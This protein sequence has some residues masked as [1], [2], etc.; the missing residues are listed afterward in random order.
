MQWLSRDNALRLFDIAVEQHRHEG[1]DKLYY[2][3]SLSRD[4]AEWQRR[5][6]YH[7]FVLLVAHPDIPLSAAEL[8]KLYR[9]KDVIERDFRL[10]KDVVELRPIYHHTDTKVRA[11]VTLCVLALLLQ[12][13]LEGRLAA[14]GRPMT[15]AAC[16]ETLATCRL[17]RYEPNELLE[18][19][20]SVTQP[21][22]EQMAILQ[23]LGLTSLIRHQELATRITPR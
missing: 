22:P 21:S 4:Q 11:H 17:N 8:A 6:R 15:A 5:R 18:F 19:D 2:Q 10:I 16:L 7:G 12:R 3:V 20:Y 23:A 14:A 1:T 9:A 13:V